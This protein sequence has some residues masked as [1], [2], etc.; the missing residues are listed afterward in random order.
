MHD[1]GLAD[2]GA[3]LSMTAP[4][5]RVT[6]RALARLRASSWLGADTLAT[7]DAFLVLGLLGVY[8]KL[9]LLAPQWGAVARFLG[10]RPGEPLGW[11]DPLGF[12]ASDVTLNLLLL[13]LAATAIVSLIFR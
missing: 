13:P 12:F 3:G 11:L 2:D 7:F 5:D 1:S 6:A 8:L 10:K 4:A 9:A